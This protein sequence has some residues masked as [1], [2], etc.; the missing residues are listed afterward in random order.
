MH[1][2]VSEAGSGAVSSYALREN[3]ILKIL[4]ASVSNGSRAACWIA[5]TDHLTPAFG[6]G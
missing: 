5:G 1:F 6:A 4:D 3:T 2:W